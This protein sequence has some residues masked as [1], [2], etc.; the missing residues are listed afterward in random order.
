M[1]NGYEDEDVM[2]DIEGLDG[3]FWNPEDGKRVSKKRKICSM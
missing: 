2:E 1:V 3:G